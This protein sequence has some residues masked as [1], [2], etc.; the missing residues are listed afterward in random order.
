MFEVNFSFLNGICG[1]DSKGKKRLRHVEWEILG[2]ALYG[3]GS[4]VGGAHRRQYALK[5]VNGL[6]FTGADHPQL[7]RGW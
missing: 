6:G 3:S 4:G 2:I 7:T 5:N 1:F